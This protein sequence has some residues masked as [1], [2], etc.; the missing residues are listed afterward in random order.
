M[1]CRGPAHLNVSE[2]KQRAEGQKRHQREKMKESVDER[3][4]GGCDGHG[5]LEVEKGSIE[6]MQ[7]GKLYIQAGCLD[8]VVLTET[9]NGKT[10]QTAGHAL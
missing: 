4:R 8:V 3:L 7:S 10:G 1:A 2:S 5:G 6:Y 9:V